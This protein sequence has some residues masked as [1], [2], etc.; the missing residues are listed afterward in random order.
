M[1]CICIFMHNIVPYEQ[2]NKLRANELYIITSSQKDTGSDY[3]WNCFAYRD[4]FNFPA[5]T[6]FYRDPG[7]SCDPGDRIYLGANA[8][9]ARPEYGQLQNLLVFFLA[10]ENKKD[11]QAVS[12]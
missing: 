4:Y 10:A 7:R 3:R 11:G 9:K 2:C 8:F 1:Q 5:G 6:V 12:C